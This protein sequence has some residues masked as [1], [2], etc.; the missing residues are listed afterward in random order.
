[1]SAPACDACPRTARWRIHP[2]CSCLLPAAGDRQYACT[3]H[4]GTVTGMWGEHQ[5][6]HTG[7]GAFE[8]DLLEDT[9]ETTVEDPL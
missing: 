5:R 8:A 4:L 2:A 1:M 9:A 6:R 3:E 7:R